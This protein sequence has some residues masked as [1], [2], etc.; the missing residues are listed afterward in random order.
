MAF[1]S[2]NLCCVTRVA[3]ESGGADDRNNEV[4]SRQRYSRTGVAMSAL[5]ITMCVCLTGVESCAAPYELRKCDC[6]DRALYNAN[7]LFVLH[8]TSNEWCSYGGE[9]TSGLQFPR[10]QTCT[11]FRLGLIGGC[12]G[13]VCSRPSMEF[14]MLTHGLFAFFLLAVIRMT[15]E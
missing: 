14:T 6:V 11:C 5:Y 3:G 2:Q 9:V 8:E 1:G 4:A 7:M 15:I 13:I 12:R 10:S